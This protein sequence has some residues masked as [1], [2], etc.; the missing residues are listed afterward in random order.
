MPRKI[1]VKLNPYKLILA[2]NSPRRKEILQYLN[3]PFSIV[4]AHTE[5]ISQKTHPM[6]LASDLARQKGFATLNLM[7][8]SAS[9][10]LLIAS[11]DTIVV[12]P[13]GEVLGKP[14]SIAE[15]RKTLMELSG[16]THHVYTGMSLI[17]YN[18]NHNHD[19][20]EPSMI[21]ERQESCKTEVTFAA[22]EADVLES[23]LQTGDSMDKAGAYGVQGMAQTFIKEI[24]G[25]YS[26]VVGLPIYEFHQML[27]NFLM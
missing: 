14:S 1:L 4:V 25:S 16:K 18:H 10:S 19:L 8:A 11:F 21:R 9:A 7:R 24:K 12:A 26:N 17:S 13:S 5:E 27:K 2:S 22:I 6:E 3:L 15:A 23:Y 20:P